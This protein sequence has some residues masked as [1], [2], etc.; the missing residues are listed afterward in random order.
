LDGASETVGLVSEEG[1]SD[2]R[3]PQ[4]V[5]TPPTSLLT[6]AGIGVQVAAELVAQRLSC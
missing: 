2:H 5:A 3:A 6:T 1:L 4:E